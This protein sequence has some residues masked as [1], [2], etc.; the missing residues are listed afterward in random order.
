MTA[1]DPTRV[2]I[3][4]QEKVRVTDGVKKRAKSART[5]SGRR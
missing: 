3:E 2:V 5:N 4:E 1:A